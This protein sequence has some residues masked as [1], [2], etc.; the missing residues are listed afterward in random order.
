MDILP[1]L[2]LVLLNPDMPCLCK[3]CRSRSVGFFRSQLIWIYT[4]C[5]S[6]REFISTIWI[7]EYDWLTIRCGHGILIYS[8]YDRSKY[9]T[10]MKIWICSFYLLFVCLKY[11]WP[12]RG[13]PYSATS[14]LGL[15]SLLRPVSP[16]SQ[17]K[18]I[19][20][21]IGADW[22]EQSTSKTLIRCG[23]WSG[24]TLFPTHPANSRHIDK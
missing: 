6:V 9:H 1:P 16:N 13:K 12:V 23:I 11:C 8:A 15:Q 24:S 7:K 10:C 3:Q 20:L 19:T 5:H 21:S 22:A 2:T 18:Y 4:V 14:D 17:S